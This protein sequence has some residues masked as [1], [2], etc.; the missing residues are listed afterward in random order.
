MFLAIGARAV[1]ANIIVPYVWY[2]RIIT[3]ET[4]TYNISRLSVLLIKEV[5]RHPIIG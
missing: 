4:S 5:P 1:S 2:L 3:V